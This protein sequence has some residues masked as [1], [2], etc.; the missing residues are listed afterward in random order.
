[1]SMGNLSFVIESD[2]NVGMQ[3][4]DDEDYDEDKKNNQMKNL[5][6]T[7]LKFNRQN[8]RYLKG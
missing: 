8:I 2:T 6:V 1:M 3:D 4:I 7:T 5:R